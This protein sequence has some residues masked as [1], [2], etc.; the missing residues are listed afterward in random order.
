MIC[1]LYK[2]ICLSI[3]H[4]IFVFI[5]VMWFFLS[6]FKEICIVLVINRKQRKLLIFEEKLNSVGFVFVIRLK[7]L[8]VM[9]F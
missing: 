4:S 2:S 1:P 5:Y 8:T 7:L 3:C 6:I 9:T